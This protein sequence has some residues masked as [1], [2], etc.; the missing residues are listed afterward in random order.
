MD[1][2]NRDRWPGKVARFNKNYPPGTSVVLI[3]D[4]GR[5]IRTEV[6]FPAMI[7]SDGTPVVWLQGIVG[8]RRFDRVIVK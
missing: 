6:Q 7:M 8:Y 1:D 4:D 5:N 3:T 2:Y